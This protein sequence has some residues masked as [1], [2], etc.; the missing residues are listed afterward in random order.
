MKKYSKLVWIL[1]ALVL[2]C[3]CGKEKTEDAV[4]NIVT[5]DT[6]AES[7]PETISETVSENVSS[8][9]EKDVF[10][11]Y[12]EYGNIDKEILEQLVVFATLHEEWY[13]Y[14]EWFK[15]NDFAVFDMDE[16]GVLELI[17][18]EVQGAGYYSEN[19]FYQV[20]DGELI[21]FEQEFI[22]PRRTV[23]QYDIGYSVWT[24]FRD[25]ET[26]RIY[27]A[28]KDIERDGRDYR[29]MADGVFWLEDGIIYNDDIRL[30]FNLY[31][32][33][34]PQNLI[35]T[36]Y[37]I[38][39]YGDEN[40]ITKAEWDQLYLDFMEGKSEG[41]TVISW[42]CF[43]EG[44]T[45]STETV[46]QKLVG[47]YEDSLLMPYAVDQGIDFDITVQLSTL[48]KNS[49][50][51]LGY[52]DEY[53]NLYESHFAVCDLDKD[54]NLEFISAMIQGTGRFSYNL[55]YG[56]RNEEVVE[57]AQPNLETEMWQ[58]E[59][60]L[61]NEPVLKTYYEEDTGIFYYEVEDY[62]RG[63]VENV[64]YLHGYM[65]LESDNIYHEIVRCYAYYWSDEEEDVEEHFYGESFV[66]EITEEEW[67]TLRDEFTEGMT[68]SETA[69]SWF[70]LTG[71]EAQDQNLIM[72]KLAES[73][74]EGTATAP[75]SQK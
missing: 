56:V 29:Y 45:I 42:Q 3:S 5:T 17:T 51:W 30:N 1:V 40:E 64:G 16:D 67:S 35:D 38:Y 33:E 71:E 75:S 7:A 54:G 63:G 25:E 12:I 8:E 6:V 68:E 61:M 44:E 24:T 21:K 73:Y 53:D 70:T 15:E 18:H 22:D 74:K 52:Y 34:S 66:D 26:G 72:K 27:F 32:L 20:Q 19:E 23:S 13:W 14:S 46:L 31:D 11:S 37:Y 28:G 47:S 2:F 39:N 58:E 62:Q 43:D 48:A 50:M 55:F 36:K 4:V 65:W 60:D 57:L 9:T 41:Q 10:N 69:F 49:D 59:F